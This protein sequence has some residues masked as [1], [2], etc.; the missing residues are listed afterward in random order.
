M[1]T[2]YDNPTRYERRPRPRSVELFR[3]ARKDTLCP[4]WVWD[5][6]REGKGQRS[7]TIEATTYRQLVYY[8][9]RRLGLSYPEIGAVTKTPHTTVLYAVRREAK[10]R[11][12]KDGG[13][14]P[15]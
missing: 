1:T 14:K 8:R 2:V 15:A 12:G 4:D 11:A 13:R 10:L 6:V 9:L 7:R 3:E 5:G